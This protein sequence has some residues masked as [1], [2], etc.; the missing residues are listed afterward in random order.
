M[1]SWILLLASVAVVVSACAP[2]PVAVRPAPVDPAL[3]LEAA[4]AQLAAGCL[5]CLIEA[6]RQYSALRADPTVGGRATAEAIRS[7]VLIAVREHELGLLDSGY[8]KAAR[9]LLDL[10]PIIAADLTPFVDMGDVLVAGPSGPTRSVSLE[11]QTRALVALSQNQPRWAELLRSRMPGDRVASYFWL[12][13]A[14]GIYGTAVPDSNDRTP[15]VGDDI[16]APLVAFKDAIACARNR[17][18]ALQATVDAEPRFREA[19]FF[20]GL[21]ALS[22]QPKPGESGGGPDLEGADQE[23]RAAYEWRQDWPALT[24]TIAGLALTEEDFARAFEFYDHTLV[25]VPRHAEA[26]LGKIR[27]LTYLQRHAD[28][29]AVADELLATG[30]NPGDARYWRALNEEQLDQHEQ[31]WDDIELADKLLVNGDVPKL[32]GIIAINRRQLEVARQK[33]ELA[34]K[35]RASVCDTNYYLQLVHSELR[36]WTRAATV[37]G[38]CAACFDKEEA[39][40]RRDIELFRTSKL[41]P[42]RRDRQIA[43]REQ[44]IAANA[45]MRA[46]AWFNAAA[47]SYNL[48]RREEARAFAQKL[49]GDQQFNERAQDLLSRLPQ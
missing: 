19:H 36:D 6:H 35:R 38:N 11:A 22:G 34:L 47:A 20:Q 46:T 29:I 16:R 5:D 33:L 1:R 13:L 7:S 17:R 2:K 18:E 48:G 15:V 10:S 4:H 23:F 3:L 49:V 25:L 32:A 31:A 9:Q 14:C 42:A 40:L 24:L 37:A 26:L 39:G 8:L 43:R 44:Q 21:A 45:R 12:S 27:A 28:A 41:P 30:V